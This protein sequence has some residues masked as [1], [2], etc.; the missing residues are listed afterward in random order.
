M[1]KKREPNDLIG[2]LFPLDKEHDTEEVREALTSL[3]IPFK[4]QESDFD[5]EFVNFK[6]S[7]AYMYNQLGKPFIKI[8]E[9]IVFVERARE[10][11]PKEEDLQKIVFQMLENKPSDQIFAVDFYL[12]LFKRIKPNFSI[13]EEGEECL[14]SEK[15]KE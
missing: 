8:I 7:E 2:D 3:N 14:Q 4:T 10:Q 5:Y 1:S 6:I 9:K 15:G 11:Y 13:V 12:R